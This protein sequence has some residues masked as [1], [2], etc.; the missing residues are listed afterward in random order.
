MSDAL[1]GEH[2]CENHQGNHSHY[3]S[4]NCTVCKLEAQKTRSQEHYIKL[5]KELQYRNSELE[6]ENDDLKTEI[7]IKAER[8]RRWREV[9]NKMVSA[10]RSGLSQDELEAME[11]FEM[12]DDGWVYVPNWMESLQEQGE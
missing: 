5:L 3:A 11:E 2:Y 4:H 8:I 7:H 12:L 1:P 10:I 6:V 9:G